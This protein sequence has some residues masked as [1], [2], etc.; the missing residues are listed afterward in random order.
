MSSF[1]DAESR[2]HV[3]ETESEELRRALSDEQLKEQLEYFNDV[4]GCVEVMTDQTPNGKKET[5]QERIQLL[6]AEMGVRRVESLSKSQHD[7]THVLGTK[8]LNWTKVAA[9]G[10]IAAVLVALIGL[11]V[12][13][14][15][16]R[17]SFTPAEARSTPAATATPMATP[18]QSATGTP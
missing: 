8:T 18:Q 17:S 15:C 6:L 11:L 9:W 4:R 10:A 16:S 14:Y 3:S 1:N 2:Q 5:C 13:A 12:S 7:E